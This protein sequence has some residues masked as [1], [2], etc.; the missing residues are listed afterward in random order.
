MP[1]ADPDFEGNSSHCP[2]SSQNLPAYGPLMLWHGRDCSALRHLP[3]KGL[4][5]ARRL[6]L[7]NRAKMY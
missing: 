6:E 5:P 4:A 2:G 1:V 3:Q 7:D